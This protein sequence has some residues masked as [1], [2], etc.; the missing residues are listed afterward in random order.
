L[1]L[2]IA[3][4][5]NWSTAIPVV[6]LAVHIVL[7]AKVFAKAKYGV[8]AQKLFVS[9]FISIFFLPEFDT[10]EMPIL[11]QFYLAVTHVENLFLI[12]PWNGMDYN[13]CNV[14]FRLGG[15]FIAKPRTLEYNASDIQPGIIPPDPTTD[16]SCIIDPI[17]IGN[18]L[19]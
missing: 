8:A 4:S 17:I 13:Y 14:N 2:A 15:G 18:L 19:S 11:A 3:T 10:V 16:S 5:H 7:F 12:V 1:A 9:V 6:I